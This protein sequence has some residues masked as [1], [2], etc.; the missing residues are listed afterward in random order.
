MNRS[1]AWPNPFIERTPKSQLRRLLVAAHVE[2]QGL[3]Q[4]V[5]RARS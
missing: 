2:L 4:F 5:K 1:Q 3:P